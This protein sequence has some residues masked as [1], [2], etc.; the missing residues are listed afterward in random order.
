MSKSH[1]EPF[2]WACFFMCQYN[3]D[4]RRI[5]AVVSQAWSFGCRTRQQKV[6][7]GPLGI[8]FHHIGHFGSWLTPRVVARVCV[9]VRLAECAV[10]KYSWY[11][12]C[13]PYA[14][15]Q[16]C[17]EVHYRASLPRRP[18]PLDMGVQF[19]KQVVLY[20]SLPVENNKWESIELRLWCQRFADLWMYSIDS[21]DRTAGNLLLILKWQRWTRHETDLFSQEYS[22]IA[23]RDLCLEVLRA[24][25]GE[26]ETTTGWFR[27]RQDG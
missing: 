7:A 17:G 10:R 24:S 6:A 3:F 2:W 25:H 15:W 20:S 19:L 23:C 5:N 12:W 22:R 11:S 26:L 18:L 14:D 4:Y 21:N 9:W 13:R 16:I 27:A 1:D 8:S